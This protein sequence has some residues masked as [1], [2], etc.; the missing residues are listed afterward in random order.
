MPTKYYST[1]SDVFRKAGISTVIWA[2]HLVRSSAA[3]MQAVARDIHDNQTVV[4][5][6]DRIAAVEEIF[7]LQDADEYSA[8][9]RLYLSAATAARSAI[10]LAAGRGRGLEAQ[11]ADRPKIMLN[12][13]GKPLLRWLVDAFKKQQ[14]NQITVVG[15][16]RADVIDTA[17]IRLVTNERHAHT[18]ELASLA[19]A[20]ESLDADTTLSSLTATCCSAVTC[21]VRW[22]RA[23]VS[24]RWSWIPPPPAPTTARCAILRTVRGRTIGACLV[25]RSDSSASPVVA[26][27]RSRAP[28]RPL[29]RMGAGSVW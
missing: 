19:C 14:I 17:G 4:N 21:C 29:R 11:T 1:P 28:S 8:A 20:I 23:R 16:Y 12:I 22:W 27:R 7:R 26:M 13:A 24:F 15:G 6:E 5:I 2:N 18:G 9:E 10:V 25:L 3:A